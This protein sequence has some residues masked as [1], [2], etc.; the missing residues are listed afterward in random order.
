MKYF[1]KP[2]AFVLL[3]L[4]LSCNSSKST[5]DKTAAEYEK[6]GYIVGTI[7]PKGNGNCGWIIYDGERNLKY[8]PVNIEDEKFVG[9][10]LK[11]QKVYFKFLPLRQKNRCE[12]TAPIRLTEVATFK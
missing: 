3:L 9:F 2:F 11:E 4:T 7:S 12:N 6:E 8:D 10:S 5:T 1:L